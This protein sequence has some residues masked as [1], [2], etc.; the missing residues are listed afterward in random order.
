MKRAVRGRSVLRRALALGAAG[1]LWVGLAPG[2]ATAAR[3]A[4]P[5]KATAWGENS[6]GQLG[7]AASAGGS[8]VPVKVCGAAPCPKPLDNVIEAAAGEWHNIALRTDGT[9]WA[10]G[11][12]SY[13]QLGDG[14]TDVRSAPVRVGSLTDV[15]AVAAGAN[16]N[17]ALRSDGTVWAWG[18]NG[19]GQLGNGTTTDSSVPVQ[20]CAENTG[21]GCTSFLTGVTAISAGG[22]HSLA[23]GAGGGLRAWGYNGDGRLGDGTTQQRLVPVPTLLTSGV[24][25]MSAGGSHSLAVVSDG[26]VRAWGGNYTGQLGD[27]TTTNRPA[28]VRVCD[29]GTTAPCTTYLSGVASVAAGP[30]HSLAVLS[31]GGVR[32]WGDNFSGQL[33]NGSARGATDSPVPV[34]VCATGTIGYCTTYLSGATAAAAGFRHSLTRQSDGTVRAWGESLD[35]QLGNGRV[36]GGGEPDYETNPVKVCAPGQTS[37]CSRFLDGVG[38]VSA[39]TYHSLAIALPR[40]DLSVTMTSDAPVANGE[41]LT[42]TITVRNGPTAADDVVLDD[43]LP[44]EG[45]FS[46]AT[47]N[48]GSCATLPPSGSSDTVTCA[49][50]RIG[51]YGQATITITVTVRATP[52][53]VITNKATVTLGNP[54]PNPGNNTATLRTTVS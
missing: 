25:S 24:K 18:G 37:P 22:A 43:S 5:G 45:R 15:T 8:S 32:S 3:S 39:G 46:S 50:G 23:L 1:L 38:A 36:P 48:R 31:N 26:T 20:V 34:R 28:P 11:D 35:G 33:G 41:S 49:L 16:H 52:G 6:F 9:V 30:E 7:D 19:S 54:D 12:N 13:G 40:P 10:W 29:V 2:E 53:T 4:L 44:G 42:Y 27:G 51:P 47:S 17:L 14:T 21:T